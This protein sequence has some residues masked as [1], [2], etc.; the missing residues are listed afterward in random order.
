MSSGSL[1]RGYDVV[2]CRG[3]GFG[4]ADRIPSQAALD[5][6]YREMSKYENLEDGGRP[7]AEDVARFRAFLPAVQRAAPS[8]EARILDV[9][10]S[11]GGLLAV[12]RD[13]GY[14]HVAGLDPS[15]AC[16]EAAQRL[17]GIEVLTSTLSALPRL[18]R[19]FDLLILAGVVEHVRDARPLLSSLPGVLSGEGTVLISVPDAVRIASSGSGPFQE[20]STEHISF[21]SLTSLGNLLSMAGFSLV[22]SQHS[23]YPHRH[24][25]VAPAVDAVFEPRNG[26]PAA[27]VPDADTEPA[28]VEYI[29][30]SQAI[31]ARLRGK[32]DAIL[33]AGQPILVWG[34]GTHTLRLLATSRLAEARIAAFVDANPHYQGKTLH[35]AP[36][37]SPADVATMTEPILISSRTCQQDIRRLIRHTLRLKNEL[38]LL[39]D[40]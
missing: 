32:L 4:Y 30:E 40:D 9:G 27:I 20:F 36:I 3:C 33:A 24:P 22:W 2:I 18:G 35:G 37:L 15:P 7:S 10:C 38:Y 8:R 29:R 13:A 12:L 6:Y 1:L 28:L 21:F 17:Y 25:A 39:Y 14:R 11:T 5:R 26:A 34:T 31:D 23:T 16:A 19:R